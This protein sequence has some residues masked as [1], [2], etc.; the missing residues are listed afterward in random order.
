MEQKQEQHMEHEQQESQM[1]TFNKFVL[2][3]SQATVKTNILL[4]PYELRLM[5][6]IFMWE[7]IKTLQPDQNGNMPVIQSDGD[8]QLSVDT[9]VNMVK[10]VYNKNY[11]DIFLKIS[12]DSFPVFKKE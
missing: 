3:F 7:Y 9:L 4:K 10:T 12:T 1:I 2:W 11:Y 8:I 6:S 5:Y